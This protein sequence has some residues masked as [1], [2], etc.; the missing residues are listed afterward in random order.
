[1]LN[2][3]PGYMLHSV[4]WSVQET[5]PLLATGKRQYFQIVQATVLLQRFEVADERRRRGGMQK[6]NFRDQRSNARG[7]FVGVWLKTRSGKEGKKRVI[8][9]VALQ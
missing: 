8:V 3:L 5:K 7:W 6:D 4:S 9:A 1:M 2:F